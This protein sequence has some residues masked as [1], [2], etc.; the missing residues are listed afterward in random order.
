MLEP[1]TL[2][3][4]TPVSSLITAV[5]PSCL[6]WECQTSPFSTVFAE[7]VTDL[8]IGHYIENISEDEDLVFIEIYKADRIADISLAQW[9]ALTPSDVAAAAI[10]VPIETIEKIKYEKQ[11]IIGG[12][13][14]TQT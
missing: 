11:L 4:V 14:R 2:R 5:R 1:S 9:L 12:G 10:N 13:N 6:P 8:F 3:L 7:Q